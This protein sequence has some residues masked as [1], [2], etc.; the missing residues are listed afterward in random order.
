MSYETDLLIDEHALDLEWLHQSSKFMKYSEKAAQADR[1]KKKAKEALDITKAEIDKSIREE[2]KNNGEK[3]TE[4]VVEGRVMLHPDYHKAYD[5]LIEAEYEYSIFISAV[6][7]MEQ[8]K[9]AL[10]NLVK[11]LIGGYFS[12]P[13]Q[14]KEEEKI[15]TTKTVSKKQ[16]DQLNKKRRMR[17]TND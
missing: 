12:I 16:K 1:E 10:E 15:D 3:V 4:K 11:L 13:T 14:K 7:A 6:K 17:K 8:R 9:S 5:A 2:A